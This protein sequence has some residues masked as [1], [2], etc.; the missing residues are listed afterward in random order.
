MKN[1]KLNKFIFHIFY[2]PN[3]GKLDFCCRFGVKLYSDTLLYKFIYGAR[4]E[5]N[6]WRIIYPLS[7]RMPLTVYAEK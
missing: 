6:A 5:S 7:R 4:K 2:L 1:E 3:L